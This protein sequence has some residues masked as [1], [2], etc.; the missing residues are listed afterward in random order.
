MGRL[1]LTSPGERNAIYL[2]PYH[3]IIARSDLAKMKGV[4]P[5]FRP[6]GQGGIVEPVFIDL[7]IHTSDNPD[8]LNRFYDLDLLKDKVERTAE[9]SPHLISLTDPTLSTNMSI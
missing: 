1:L 4:S 2:I 5:M 8:N 6:N 3:T 7:H 9:G